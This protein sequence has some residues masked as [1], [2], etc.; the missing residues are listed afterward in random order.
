MFILRQNIIFKYSHKRE[1]VICSKCNGI[2]NPGVQ[3]YIAG[4][5]LKNIFIKLNKMKNRKFLIKEWSITD[6]HEKKDYTGMKSEVLKISC[7][8]ISAGK[9]KKI[10]TQ[11]ILNCIFEKLS[12]IS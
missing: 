11:D 8:F 1:V 5:A 4:V 9:T 2:S 12:T 3:A 7:E 10:T 6:R